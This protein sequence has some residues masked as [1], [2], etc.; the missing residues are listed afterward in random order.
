MA[1]AHRKTTTD[2]AS[3]HRR[4]RGDCRECQENASADDLV[5]ASRVARPGIMRYGSA[6]I[7]DQVRTRRYDT[8]QANL[9]YRLMSRSGDAWRFTVQEAA[10]VLKLLTRTLF[11]LALLQGV[12]GAQT[13]ASPST[14]VDPFGASRLA[15][16]P[17]DQQPVQ[18]RNDSLWN[19]VIVGA[20]LGALVGVAGSPLI[21]DCSECSGFNVPLTF[22]VLG[23]GI[24][25]GVGAGIDALRNSK[26]PHRPHVQLA[27]VVSKDTRGLLAWIRF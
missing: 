8:L 10:Q 16:P 24:G 1:V 3:H 5:M 17:V 11:A 4:D 20:G 26:A 7:N 25:A 14:S 6:R 12:A 9:S 13:V 22:G 21:S 18:Q 15:F 23:A 2:S 19:G 27:P